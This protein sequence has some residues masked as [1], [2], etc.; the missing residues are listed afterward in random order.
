MKWT[1]SIYVMYWKRLFLNVRDRNGNGKFYIAF[2]TM[3]FK[4][5]KPARNLRRQYEIEKYN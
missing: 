3:Q 1:K 4:Q 5:G 2:W